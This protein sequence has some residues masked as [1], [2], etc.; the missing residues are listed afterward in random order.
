VRGTV[1]LR[2]GT[3]TL[4]R[5]V[6]GSAVH[7]RAAA[8]TFRS[9]SRPR[10]AA[11]LSPRLLDVQA[12]PSLTFTSTDLVL[13]S[14]WTPGRE[15]GPWLLRGELEVRGVTRLVEARITVLPGAGASAGGQ[16]DAT[17][18][19]SARLSVDRYDFGLTAYRGLAAR[20]L[21]IDVSIVAELVQPDRLPPGTAA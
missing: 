6:T 17:L 15:P 2:D 8:S 20:W 12:Y 11:V 10:D 7:A 13:E 3:I 5:P 18:R 16:R 14:P 9:G 21:T 4:V 19:A 1:A